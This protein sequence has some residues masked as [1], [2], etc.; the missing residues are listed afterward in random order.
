MAV[1]IERKFLVN[2]KWT[3]EGRTIHVKQGYLPGTGPMLVRVRQE[4]SRAFLTLK[5]RT[6]GITRS[7]YEYEIPMEDAG[8]L[9]E[10]CE[11][12]IIEKTRYLI[13]AGPHTWEVDVFFGANEGLVVAEIELS[14]ENESFEKPA[15][16]GAEVSGDVRYYNSNL[17]SHPY[18]EWKNDAPVHRNEQ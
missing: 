14:D 10:R 5:G 2:E 17:A 18:S 11:R 15:W 6:E 1:E 13:P 4:D 9:L 16:L 7:E 8:E 3:P 12:P